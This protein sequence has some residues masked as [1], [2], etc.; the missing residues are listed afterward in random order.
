MASCAHPWLNV[1]NVVK[2]TC[3]VEQSHERYLIQ[4]SLLADE[5]MPFSARGLHT[6]DILDRRK[7]T[8]YHSAHL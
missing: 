5:T 8:K 3:V 4:K 6:G 1:R 7:A 2:A